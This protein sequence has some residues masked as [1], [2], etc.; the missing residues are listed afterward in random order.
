MLD[1]FLKFLGIEDYV[2]S[3]EIV[4]SVL[5]ALIVIAAALTLYMFICFFQFILKILHS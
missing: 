3:S 4:S 2:I 1:L 5:P